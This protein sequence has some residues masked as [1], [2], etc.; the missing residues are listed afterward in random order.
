[1][2][3]TGD[4]G[5]VEHETGSDADADSEES[6]SDDATAAKR[7]RRADDAPAAVTTP[8]SPRTDP[9]AARSSRSSR[10]PWKP[11][12]LERACR[13]VGVAGRHSRGVL[14]A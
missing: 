4:V 8:A 3:P 12:L 11:T 13:Q 14:A 10:T 9:V 7:G 1:M 6:D 2:R 5:P